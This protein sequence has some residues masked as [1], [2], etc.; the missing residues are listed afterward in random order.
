MS[1]L[2]KTTIAKHV[3]NSNFRR[4]KGSSFIENI[5]EVSEQTNG[6]VQIQK[7]LLYDLSGREVKIQNASE[8]KIKIEDAISCKR[9]L[10]VLDD[11]DHMDQYDALLTMQDLF[12]P[13]S[14]I[15]ITTRHARLLKAH[16]VT[17]VH[18]VHTMNYNESMKLFSWHA[19]QQDRPIDGYMEHSKK[20]VEHCGGLPLAL[21]VM[22]SSLLG[23]SVA[24]WG[25]ALQKLEAI[26]NSEIMNKL[27]ISY[28]SLGDNHDQ[29]LFLH[30]ACFFIGRDKGYI[31]RILDGCDFY[32]T[33]GI[34]N[35]IDRCLVSVDRHN[36]VQ[37]HYMIRDMAR[38]IVRLASKE[39]GKRSRLW[40]HKDSFRVL[41]EKNVGDLVF[42]CMYVFLLAELCPTVFSS[43]STY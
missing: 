18:N 5:R 43:F 17:E 28:D 11:V 12:Y 20:F 29:E 14:K 31:V 3:Y 37:M 23:E 15:I 35:L 30:I 38:G 8:G 41:R 6:L 36:K 2:G 24:V 42:M 1:G 39:P 22:G 34:V 9:V 16:G 21:Q 26:P 32:T 25:S 19:F 7:Q 40:H 13:G 27:R 33:V 10:L 4:F